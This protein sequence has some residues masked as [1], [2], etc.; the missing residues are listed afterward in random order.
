MSPAAE[1]VGERRELQN[2]MIGIVEVPFATQRRVESGLPNAEA[3]ARGNRLAVIFGF[4]FLNV[5]WARPGL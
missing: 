5:W 2:P 1:E 4:T 3:A